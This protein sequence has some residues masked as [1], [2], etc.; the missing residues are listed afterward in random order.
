[1]MK[2]VDMCRPRAAVLGLAAVAAAAALGPVTPAAAQTIGYA[3]AIDILADSCGEDILKHCKGINLGGGRI[4]GCLARNPKVSQACKVDLVR[5]QELL[6]ARAAAQAAVGQICNRDAQQFCK[7]TK[8]GK[9]NI[10][11]CLLKAA[12]SVGANCNAA[13]DAAGYR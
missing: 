11:N 6:A 4:E 9:G 1:M 8:P 2:C 13:I 3:E 5:V 7:K 12:P 10:L